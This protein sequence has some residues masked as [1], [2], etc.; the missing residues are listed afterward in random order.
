MSQENVEIVKKFIA[1]AGTDY[2][3]MDYTDLFSDEVAWGAFKGAIEPL[4]A[5]DF[6]GAFVASGLRME[7]AGLDGMR[8]AFLEWLTPWTSYYD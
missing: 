2:A 5:S 3:E 4:F 1:P 6:E 8:R 7:F